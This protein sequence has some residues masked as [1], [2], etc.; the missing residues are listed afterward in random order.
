MSPKLAIVILVV[1]AIVFATSVGAGLMREPEKGDPNHPPSLGL[2][3]N[4]LL[5]FLSPPLDLADVSV[6]VGGN[7]CELRKN[8]RLL[9]LRPKGPGGLTCKLRVRP[10]TSDDP[11]IARVELLTKDA[12]VHVIAWED[13]PPKDVGPEKMKPGDRVTLA[14]RKNGGFIEFTVA[15][16]KPCQVRFVE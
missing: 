7:A 5:G 6:V 12:G 10:I 15:G 13:E 9:I 1:L 8:D 16:Q 3:L 14:F 2:T 4:D 11:R